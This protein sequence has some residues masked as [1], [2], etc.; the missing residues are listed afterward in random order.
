V[1]AK[2]GA[3]QLDRTDTIRCQ[4]FR[5][6]WEEPLSLSQLSWMS[7]SAKNLFDF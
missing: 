5:Q 6:T 7:C 4:S 3:G 2:Q 1:Q